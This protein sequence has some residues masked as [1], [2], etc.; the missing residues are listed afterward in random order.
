MHL[1]SIVSFI[2]AAEYLSR[3]GEL[4]INLSQKVLSLLMGEIVR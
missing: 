2:E 4:M 1:A 3:L